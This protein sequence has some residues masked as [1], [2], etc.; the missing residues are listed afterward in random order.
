[1]TEMMDQE[2]TSSSGDT[3]QQTRDTLLMIRKTRSRTRHREVLEKKAIARVTTKRER[4]AKCQN[5]TAKRMPSLPQIRVMSHRN[6]KLAI[7]QQK[8]KINWKLGCQ[9]RHLAGQANKE[10][11][12]AKNNCTTYP[13]SAEIPP[14]IRERRRGNFGVSASGGN[15]R[16]V[17][18]Y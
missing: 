12:L 11:I 18:Q 8:T 15:G 1:M 5:R 17:F 9:I 10:M 2:M 14:G 13:V 16:F 3:S 7:P 4:S 6:L